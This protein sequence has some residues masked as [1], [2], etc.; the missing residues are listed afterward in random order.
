MEEISWMKRNT[1]E[2]LK[3]AQEKRSLLQT[4][5]NRRTEM[6]GHLTRHDSSLRSIMEGKIEGKR[7]KGRQRRSYLAQISEKVSHVS[8]QEIKAKAPNKDITP[9]TRDT[10]RRDQEIRRRN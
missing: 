3:V 9:P 10:R 6:F 8:Y 7:A 5:E 2:V 1:N 4:L